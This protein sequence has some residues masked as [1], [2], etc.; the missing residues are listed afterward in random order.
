MSNTENGDE[1]ES[2]RFRFLACNWREQ[3]SETLSSMDGEEAGWP[4]FGTLPTHQ[5]NQGL[6]SR[7]FVIVE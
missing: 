5:V 6:T 2:T 3:S 7:T 1:W 4:D